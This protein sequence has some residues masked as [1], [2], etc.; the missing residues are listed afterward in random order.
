MKTTL[1]EKINGVGTAQL[2][3]TVTAVQESPALGRFTFAIENRWIDAGENRS[4]AM[5]FSGAGQRL[6]RKTRLFMAADEPEILLGRDQAP[7]PVEHLLHALAACVTTSM[8]YHAAA[9]GIAI[10]AVE[11]TLDGDLD[12]QGFLGLDPAVRKGY[13]QI[14]VKLRIKADVTDEQW[15]ELM[16]LGP[17]FS[18][19]FD[20]VSRGVPIAVSAERFS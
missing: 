20:S 16:A 3:E 17:R 6:S 4:E 14:R 7:N 11:S 9:R 15:N 18:P 2:Q 1:I 19:V 8:V 10:E 12:L 5:P 13:Q